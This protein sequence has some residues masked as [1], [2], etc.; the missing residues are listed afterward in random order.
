MKAVT[1]TNS[2]LEVTD[3]PDPQPERGQLLV[4]VLRCGICGSDLHVR[5]H[6]DDLADVTAEMG[7]DRMMR[8]GEPVVLGHEYCGEVIDHGPRTPKRLRT[9]TRVV[10]MPLIRSGREVH[11]V[12]LS[13]LAPGGYAERLLMQEALALPVPNG[14][15]TRIATLTEPMAVGLH[16]VRR[17]GIGKRQTA[18]V[19]GCG[20]VGLAVIGMLKATGVRTVIASDFSPG[21]RALARALGADVVV[22]P[23][24]VSPFA[25]SSERG[26]FTSAP[27]VFDLAVSTVERMRRLPF[28][29]WWQ[30]WRAAEAVGL[31]ELKHPVVFECVGVPGMIDKL[32]TDAPISSRVVVVGVCM[33]PDRLR[34]VMAINKEIDLRF[35]LGYTPLDFR[36]A[37]HLLAE[38]KVNAAPIVTGEVGLGGVDAAFTALADPEQHA[39]ILVDPRSD[40][41]A[42]QPISGGAR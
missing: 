16:A 17:S 42:P 26:F 22:D 27:A 24:Q 40:A 4:D 21:R 38:G 28:V 9:G 31:A 25:S 11:P 7:Y 33:E 14:L 30:I 12:G 18:I 32:I 23:A 1:C 2:V 10:A 13:V 19:I 37:L 29:S 39:K 36:D 6:A 20:P 34:P 3:V 5:H 15:P 41:V 8:A 35:V